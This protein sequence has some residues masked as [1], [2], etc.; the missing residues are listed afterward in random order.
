VALHV[1][2]CVHS[3][4]A[5][6]MLDLETVLVHDSQSGEAK[7]L[8]IRDL[9]PVGPPPETRVPTGAVDLVS[10]PEAAWQIAQ[11]RFAVI[12]PLLTT[13]HATRAHVA[14][15]ARMAGVHLATVYRWLQRYQQSGCVSA[16]IPSERLG[17]RGQSRLAA[18]V[19]AIVQTTIEEVYLSAQKPSV[20]HLG[21]EVRRRCR[22]AGVLP[23][24]PNTVR[25]RIRH[26]AE[27]VQLRQREGA[28][29]AADRYAPLRGTFPGADWPLAVVQVDHTPVDLIVVDD[30][31]R[32]PVGRPWLTV[33]ID[34][35][36]RVVTG[37]YVSFD[38]PGAMAVG[39]CLAHAILPK[40]TWLAQH[41][42]V[43]PWPVWGV[44]H[45]VHADNAK[46]FRGRMLRK[47]CEN[48]GIDIHWRPVAQPH[49]GG[50]IERLLGT[51]NREIHTL[52]GTTFS[53]PTARGAYDVEKNA[54]LTLSEFERWLTMYN[55]W[56]DMRQGSSARQ[57]A[58]GV[59][60]RIACSTKR[61]CVST[62]CPMK[63][64]PCNPMALSLTRSI[65]MTMS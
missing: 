62:S 58:L 50:H 15:R 11:T 57:N 22:N 27:K 36:S 24:H 65:T 25:Y 51:F 42:I 5:K 34:V 32:R 18:D 54:A 59:G 56:H 28:K 9:A 55:R 37:L 17:G 38:P 26:L 20:Q 63:S 47:A 53:S 6:S 40:E 35:C 8:K 2:K 3:D 64:A 23:P 49:Y 46:E 52:P 19:E 21:V 45:V 41:D 30:I 12:R 39:L 1:P 60:Y 33:A 44:M 61:G 13:P 43:T 31:N 29:A 4:V 14:E 16:L 10:V 7:R 48:Y